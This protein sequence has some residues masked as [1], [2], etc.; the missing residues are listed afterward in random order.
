MVPLRLKI[1]GKTTR[2]LLVEIHR[3]IPELAEFVPVTT[4]QQWSEIPS[5]GRLFASGFNY[6]HNAGTRLDSTACE[7]SLRLA[8]MAGSAYPTPLVGIVD[9]HGDG[10]TLKTMQALGDL[11]PRDLRRSALLSGSLHG[12]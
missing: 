2:A 8:R 11:G 9:D 7:S 10:F 3:L 5:P 12:H 4:I 1:S 6:R